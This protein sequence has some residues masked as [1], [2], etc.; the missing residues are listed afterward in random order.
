MS[1]LSTVEAKR[2]W[3][4]SHWKTLVIAIVL[5]LIGIGIGAAAGGSTKT[6]TRTVAGPTINH[7]ISVTKKVPVTH[8]VYRTRAVTR[9]VQAPPPPPPP[10]PPPPSG[11]SDKDFA[12]Q[13]LQIQD[14]G[15]GDIGGIAR[16]TNT[17][18]NALTGVFT[19]T[20]FQGGQ[21]V[22]TAQGSA[23]SVAPGQTVTVQLVSQDR[24]IS[25]S[26][27]YQFQVDSEG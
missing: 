14:D 16:I 4:R 13:A 7:T 27:R 26:F 18:S 1:E 12:V 21:V 6:K 24:M 9:T 10:A 19:F 3:M 5:F 17:A 2:N 22:G 11:P 25:G 23:Q 15:V 20:F 8:I